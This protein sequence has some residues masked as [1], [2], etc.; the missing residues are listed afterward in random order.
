VMRGRITAHSYARRE[1]FSTVGSILH[2]GEGPPGV[3]LPLP[4]PP[5]VPSLAAPLA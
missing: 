2:I 4:I 1:R 5:R 3:L